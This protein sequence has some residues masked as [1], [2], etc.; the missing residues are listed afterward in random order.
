MMARLL[1]RD[2]PETA[3]IEPQ[4]CL[5]LDDRLFK[6]ERQAFDAA[7]NVVSM[8]LFAIERRDTSYW[9]VPDGHRPVTEEAWEAHFQFLDLDIDEGAAFWEAFEIDVRDADDD[10]LACLAWLGRQFVCALKRIH[11]KADARFLGGM[12]SDVQLQADAEAWA[13]KLLAKR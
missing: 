4:A 11:P 2:V 10:E 5:A 1:L 9:M 8:K 7:I 3:Q 12:K 13:A 6:D